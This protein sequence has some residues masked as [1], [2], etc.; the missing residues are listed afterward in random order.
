MCCIEL[1]IITLGY[2]DTGSADLWVISDE[3]TSKLCQKATVPSYP[4]AN[5]K[6]SGATVNLTYGDSATG[7]FAY[8][9]PS[10]LLAVD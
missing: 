6:D 9:I 8:V 2:L 4:T 1:F 3:C 7:T 10:S 5:F